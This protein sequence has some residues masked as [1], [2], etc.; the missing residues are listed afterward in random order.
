MKKANGTATTNGAAKGKNPRARKAGRGGKPKK[1]TVEEMDAEMAD[2][3]V[4]GTNAP[5]PAAATNGGDAGMVD[6]VM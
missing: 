6:E 3:F 2:Y 1:K 5:A 4:A